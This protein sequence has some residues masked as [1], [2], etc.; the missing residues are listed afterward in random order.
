MVEPLLDEMLA[1]IQ[2]DG[3]EAPK[4][5]ANPEADAAMNDGESAY[6]RG[7]LD[8]ALS[9][10]AR[11]LQLD[12]KL[13]EAALFAGDMQFKRGHN[14]TDPAARSDL[15]EKA[16]EWFAKA[17]A[18]NPDRETAYRYWGNTLLEYGKDDEART[19]FVEAIVA[20]PYNQLVYTG[21]TKWGRRS[22]C[23]SRIRALMFR[24]A[25]HRASPVK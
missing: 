14:S 7:E 18:L 2:T 8:K 12:P 23:R 9:A 16:G 20:D 10:Y 3:G 13:Y 25:L 5:S 6:T 1:S 17:I 22:R 11:A 4:F 24:P 19:K 21:L 15:F